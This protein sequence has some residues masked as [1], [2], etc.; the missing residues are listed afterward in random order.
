[1]IVA[2][3]QALC[4]LDAKGDARGVVGKEKM[5]MTV[6]LD[7]RLYG[8]EGNRRIEDE[9]IRELVDWVTEQRNIRE[10]VEDM[11]E[12]GD[13][14]RLVADQRGATRRYPVMP[15]AV[16]QLPSSCVVAKGQRMIE[17]ILPVIP[18]FEAI[19]SCHKEGYAS[20]PK[21]AFEVRG[22]DGMGL[23]KGDQG[24][25]VAAF[26]SMDLLHGGKGG[27]EYAGEFAD[28]TVVKANGK[29]GK[30][31]GLSGGGLPPA[32]PVAIDNKGRPVDGMAGERR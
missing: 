22:P 14:C 2:I 31:A 8:G 3:C 7:H 20:F 4:S 1:M 24:N 11:P 26:G 16:E 29:I 25:A 5:D 21:E 30:D 32:V 18:G 23:V 12:D 9:K 10:L 17:L 27:A 6:R 19:L 15:V 13:G 28:G